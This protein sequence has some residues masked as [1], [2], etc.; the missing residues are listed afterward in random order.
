MANYLIFFFPHLTFPRTLPNMH[1][2]ISAKMD[3][4]TEACGRFDSIYYGATPPPS[5]T[6]EEP[7]CTCAVR[8]IFLT[9]GVVILSLYCSRAQLLPLTFSLECLGKTKLQ[10]TLLDKLQLLSPGVH[11]PQVQLTFTSCLVYCNSLWRLIFSI[12]I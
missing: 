11:L 12:L 9:S 10:F 3:S 4:S 7:S 5:L 1:V 8:E 2:Q 6:P